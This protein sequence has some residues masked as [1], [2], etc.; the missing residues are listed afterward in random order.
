MVFTILLCYYSCFASGPFNNNLSLVQN[1]LFEPVFGHFHV[2]GLSD[3]LG[4]PDW[5]FAIF[6]QG[7]FVQAHSRNL[8]MFEQFDK[9]WSWGQ[10]RQHVTI[11][12]LQLRPTAE[13]IVRVCVCPW[14]KSYDTSSHTL[15]LIF[16]MEL[17]ID[18]VRKLT[19]PDF[20]GKICII[21]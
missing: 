2:F 4:I 19:R 14:F 1:Y 3:R 8:K 6:K 7:A 16:C 9:F 10:V 21:Q 12:Q 20:P 18:K 5:I 11:P 15:V 13:K 17:H